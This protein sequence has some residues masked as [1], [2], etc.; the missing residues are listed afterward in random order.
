MEESGEETNT[1]LEQSKSKEDMVWKPKYD[2]EFD[3]EQAAYDFYNEYGQNE[4]FS[5]RKEVCAKDK[6]HVLTS[7][8]FVCCKEGLRGKDKRDDLTKN[9]RAHTWTGCGA[10]MGIRLVRRTGKYCVYRFHEEHNHPLVKQECVHRL[11]SQRKMT[12]PDGAFLELT[13][14]SGVPSKSAFELMSKEAG[15]RESLGFTKED[16]KNYL[17][18]AY[19]LYVS[20]H[21]PMMVGNDQYMQLLRRP[22]NILDLNMSNGMFWM[23]SQESFAASTQ[24]YVQS[25]IIGFPS[26]LQ[27][28]GMSN[29]QEL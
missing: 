26:T 4:G 29:H 15:G 18:T 8:L 17:R 16:Q 23:P 13:S 22:Y 20:I 19:C 7:R 9:P 1:S 28:P 5:I 6:N 27:D 3:S 14:N 2:M 11:P 21:P 12:T 24:A 10:H 25:N